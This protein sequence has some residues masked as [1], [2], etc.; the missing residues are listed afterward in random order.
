MTASLC[1]LHRHLDGSLRPQTYLALAEAEGLGALE[2]P[3]FTP[4][5]GLDAALGCFAATLRVLQRPEA[6]ERVAA[7]MVEDARSDGVSTLEI[8][9]APQLHV[10]STAGLDQLRRVVDAASAGVAGEAGL[11]LCLLYGQ[12]TAL[13][14]ALVDLAVEHPAV[15]GVDLAGGPAPDQSV[16]MHHYGPA[17]QRARA[18][19]LG[20]TVHAGEGRPPAEIA[21]AIE[22]LGATRIGHG[23][24]LLEDE[25][26][27]DLVLER[28]VTIEACLT[29]NVH[30]DA[31]ADVKDHPL[32]LWLRRGVRAT[33]C[34]DNTLLSAVT[35]SSERAEALSI[36]GMTP[37]LLALSDRHG[38]AGAFRRG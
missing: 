12:P 26:V 28:Q 32:P 21:Q 7:E 25:R 14:E 23:T 33:V 34:T 29:S 1:D 22:L 13:A 37:A 8:R 31:I 4:G 20:V 27:V 10:A 24:T 18:S 16:R 36:P 17:F 15:V 35:A 38:H 9:F 2:V 5:M 11:I 19:G 3:R 30:V 6:V